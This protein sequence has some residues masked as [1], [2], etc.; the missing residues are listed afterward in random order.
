MWLGIRRRGRRVT[1]N[2]LLGAPDATVA[3]RRA[4]ATLR[5][6]RPAASPAATA[7]PL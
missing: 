5:A 2:R 3:R 1:L 4:Y 6:L 7:F